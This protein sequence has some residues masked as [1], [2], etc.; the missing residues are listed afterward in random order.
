MPSTME[1]LTAHGDDSLQHL[2]RRVAASVAG[3]ACPASSATAFGGPEEQE[4]LRRRMDE[5]MLHEEYHNSIRGEDGEVPLEA[6]GSPPETEIG[7]FPYSGPSTDIAETV[8]IP[9]RTRE[10]GYPRAWH[11]DLPT[12]SRARENSLDPLHPEQTHGALDRTAQ[13]L[14]KLLSGFEDPDVTALSEAVKAQLGITE[15][16]PKETLLSPSPG[17]TKLADDLKRSRV[18]RLLPKV[19][20]PSPFHPRARTVPIAELHDVPVTEAEKR[21]L[22]GLALLVGVPPTPSGL[23]PGGEKTGRP[24]AQANIQLELP[25]FDPKNLPKWAEEFA[26]F[27]LLTG[28]S[29]VDVA[30][31]CSLLKR[32]CQK[33]FLQKQVKQ[34]VKTCSAWA[35]VLQ[36]TEK[37]FPVYDTDLSVRTQMEELPMPPE[38]PSAARVSE[39]VCHLEYLFSRMNVASYGATEL[40]LWLMSKIPSRT[41]DH[42][43]ATSERKSRTHSY[44]D[45]VNLLIELALERENDSHMEKFLEKHLGRG[46]TPTPECGEGKGPK[47]PT[48]ANQ[49]GGKGR[50]NL[51]AMNEVKPDAG[52]PPLFYCKP[53]ND[54]G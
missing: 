4:D 2:R 6:L 7:S 42:C 5:Y 1:A 22:S 32:S 50:G 23:T 21:G 31:K 19:T 35:E 14:A 8:S 13:L 34:I 20:C 26:E 29:H 52:T 39:Y 44:N 11:P 37:T 48:N 28:Q 9:R 17:L 51:R 12:T 36:R 47:N 33:K 30:T 45:L 41:W 54:K 3:S 46:G 16:L 49:G 53:V 18:S 27:L 10:Q 38:F 25:E 40:H 15:P 43:R 24:I